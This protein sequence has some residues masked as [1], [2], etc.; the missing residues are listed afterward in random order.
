MFL[1]SQYTVT[2]VFGLG[3]HAECVL[4]S[5]KWSTLSSAGCSTQSPAAYV[6]LQ[7]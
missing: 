4:F 6:C 3:W 1:D 2:C 7:W 5:Y